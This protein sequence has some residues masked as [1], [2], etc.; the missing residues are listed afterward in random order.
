MR[1]FTAIGLAPEAS[2]TLRSV[3]EQLCASGGDLRWSAP[4]SWHVTLQFLGNTQ[5][6]QVACVVLRL[7]EVHAR[8]VPVRL[9]GLGFVERAGIFFAEVA[10]TPEL[11][12]L[13]QKV[14][15][16]NRRCG[17]VPEVRPYSPHITLA[18]SKGRSGAR[19]LFPLKKALEQSR[20]HLAAE[21]VAQ[22][23]RLYESF[24]GPEGSRY[25]VRAQFPLGLEP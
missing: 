14:V 6:E 11:L 10:L 20:V 3:R 4:E 22:E 25:E 5:G 15:A 7:A 12:E 1:L 17:F 8:R 24:P 18:R 2:A 13:Q 16:V 19:A 9:A 23:F 21:F